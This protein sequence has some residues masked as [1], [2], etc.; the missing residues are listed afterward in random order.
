METE[1]RLIHIFRI[2]TKIRRGKWKRGADRNRHLPPGVGQSTWQ[3]P[4][5]PSPIMAS[6]RSENPDQ[7]TQCRELASR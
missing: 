7:E 2:Q 3:S 4:P 6:L 5:G 1:D